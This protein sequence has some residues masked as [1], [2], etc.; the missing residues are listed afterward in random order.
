MGNSPCI[1]HIPYI[2][3]YNKHILK[4]YFDGDTAVVLHMGNIE[5]PIDVTW[6]LAV[7]VKLVCLVQA[8]F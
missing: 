7:K 8:G 2:K 6:I 4:Y 5:S 1:L 3:K